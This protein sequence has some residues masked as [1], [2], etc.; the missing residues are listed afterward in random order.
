MLSGH[1]VQQGALRDSFTVQLDTNRV[2]VRYGLQICVKTDRE[3]TPVLLWRN[4]RFINAL[5]VEKGQADFG[6][7]YLKPGQNRF[8]LWM[9]IAQGR[10]V[11]VD[12]FSVHLRAPRLAYL[13]KQVSRTHTNQKIV[14]LTFDG[15]SSDRGTQNILDTLRSRHV[16]CT[17][18]LTGGFIRRYPQLVKEISTDGHEVGN[19]CFSHP[20]LTNLELDGS[21][22]TRTGIT[23]EILWNELL[24]T[25]SLF[26]QTSGHPMVA[27]WRA[28]FGE[29]NNDILLWA[30]EIGFK[31]INW[32]QHCDSWD[33][34]ADTSS[35]LY[36]SSTE[37]LSHFLTLES[38]KGLQ[39]KILLM[40]LGTERKK[41]YPYTILGKL[42]DELRSKGYR[43]VRVTNL[44]NNREYQIE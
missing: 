32:C 40:H 11:L 37:I 24:K 4:G 7:Q 2:A 5:P 14:A 19:H 38:E 33:W 22:H 8:G 29:L 23:R 27:L 20:H 26:K 6:T 34:V 18:F 43:F 39:G 1:P 15:G 12:S 28:P 9:Q 31:H 21:Q 36:R 10:S 41:D 25:D 3:K 44:L 30:A 42:I 16:H 35:Q 17:M 13:K